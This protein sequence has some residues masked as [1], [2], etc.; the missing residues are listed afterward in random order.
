MTRLRIQHLPGGAAVQLLRPES[1]AV[2]EL[3]VPQLLELI[4]Q[5][6]SARAMLTLPA[7]TVGEL[8]ARY[9]VSPE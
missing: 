8:I 5:A 9:G 4:S 1:W 2:L 3:T 7:A 6:E